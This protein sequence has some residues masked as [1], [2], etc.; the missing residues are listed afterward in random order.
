MKKSEVKSLAK[1]WKSLEIQLSD[2]IF[3]SRVCPRNIRHIM[4]YKNSFSDTHRCLECGEKINYGRS[5]KVYCSDTCRHHHNNRKSSSRAHIER[6]NRYLTGNYRI[7]RS[8]LEQGRTSI[9]LKELDLAGYKA[10][11]VTGYSKVNKHAELSCFD[12]RFIQTDTKI[13]ALTSLV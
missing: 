2:A 11:F 6:V 4:D 1:L 10:G 12:L 7:L 13:Y 5:D 9:P 8:F 3:A